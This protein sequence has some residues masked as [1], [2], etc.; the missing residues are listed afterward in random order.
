L[1]ESAIVRHLQDAKNRDVMDQ[2]ASIQ[3]DMSLVWDKSCYSSFTSTTN[4]YRLEKNNNSVKSYISIGICNTDQSA[5]SHSLRS[6]MQPFDWSLCMFCQ[7]PSQTNLLAVT[8][9]KMNQQILDK[10][11]YDQVLSVQLSSVHVLIA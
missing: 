1:K 9:F 11:K 5:S 6:S 10:Y 4:I 8:T 7:I 2:I 3:E